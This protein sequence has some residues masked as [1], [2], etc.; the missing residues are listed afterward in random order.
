VHYFDESGHFAFLE[1][2][3]DVYVYVQAA[4]DLS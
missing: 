4:A 1:S 3:Y 2:R